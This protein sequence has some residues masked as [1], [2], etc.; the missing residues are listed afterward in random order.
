MKKQFEERKVKMLYGPRSETDDRFLLRIRDREKEK[1]E[2]LDQV[3]LYRA[4][5]LDLLMVTTVVQ[6]DKPEEAT[7]FHT[8]GEDT[9]LSMVLGTADKKK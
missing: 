7:A 3:H 1:D 8:T 9:C 2:T 6:T 4:A 5:G